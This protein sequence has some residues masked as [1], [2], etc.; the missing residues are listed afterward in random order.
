M[1]RIGTNNPRCQTCF[2]HQTEMPHGVQSGLCVGR[3][4]FACAHYLNPRAGRRPPSQYNR[5][6]PAGD[7][8]WVSLRLG[9]LRRLMPYRG[10]FVCR[11]WFAFG[12]G[13]GF[14]RPAWRWFRL[15]L[16]LVLVWCWFWSSAFGLGFGRV[17]WF[18]F[19]F[20]LFGASCW[21]TQAKN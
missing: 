18:R 13:F 11:C 4:F 8:V 17:R 14:G 7:R 19:I 20:P 3:P 15:S 21:S 6:H 5:V 12:V 9:P 10:G 1:R 2:N 16:F